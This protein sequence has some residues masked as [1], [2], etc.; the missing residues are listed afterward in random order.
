MDSSAIYVTVASNDVTNTSGSSA[1]FWN[2][3]TVPVDLPGPEW[4]VALFS[5]T[6][7]P[8]PSADG[9]VL[10]NASVVERTVTVGSKQS[11]LL[12]QILVD[13]A[14]GTQLQWE[15]PSLLQ[16]VPSNAT[17]VLNFIEVEITDQNGNDLPMEADGVSFVTLAFRP[18][19][20]PMVKNKRW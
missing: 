2:N 7:K 5:A 8:K 1:E 18:I 17:G 6:F 20:V 14:G 10:I 19:L 9:I 16:W 4:E 3:I 12:R 11:P 13:N 15:T